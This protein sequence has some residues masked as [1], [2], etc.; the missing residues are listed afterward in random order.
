MH[1]LL[2]WIALGF[3]AFVAF[4]SALTVAAVVWVMSAVVYV[5]WHALIGIIALGLL[6]WAVRLVRRPI[7]SEFVGDQVSAEE[8]G[9]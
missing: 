3:F 6:I 9:R 8:H 4:G 7:A 2:A 5:V 1:A